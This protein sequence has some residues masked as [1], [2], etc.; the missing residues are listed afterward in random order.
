MKTD[1]EQMTFAELRA[2]ALAHRD[3]VEPLREIYR[4]RSPDSEAV[5][6]KLPQS[7]EEEEQQ[8]EQLRKILSKSPKTDS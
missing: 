3:D 1:F 2:Y 6:F 4:R 8:A 7:K 5:W